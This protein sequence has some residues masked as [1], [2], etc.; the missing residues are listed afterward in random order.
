M[1]SNQKN[2]LDINPDRSMGLDFDS[3]LPLYHQLKEIIKKQIYDNAWQRDEMIPS[4]N[5]LAAGFGISAGTVK[6]AI[7]ELVHEGL[8]YRRQGKGTFIARPDFKRSFIRFF[9]YGS[10]GQAEG[11]TPASRVL[12]SEIISPEARVR[13]VLKLADD[14]RVIIIQRLRILEDVPFMLEYIFLPER[15]FRGFEQVDISRELL[16]PIYDQKFQTPI[17]WAEEYLE[18]EIAHEDVAAHLSITPGVPVISI[19]R[20]AYTHGDRPV[21]YRRSIGRGDRFRYHIVLR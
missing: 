8:L 18:P 15:T 7:S 4:E 2:N 17:I 16:Y 3:A 9:R 11:Q 5:E 19:E 12:H 10:G 21:E 1:N 13:E 6:K 14:D 20:I